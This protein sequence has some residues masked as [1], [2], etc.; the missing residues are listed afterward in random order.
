MLV[1][2]C[3]AALLAGC[4]SGRSSEV[5]PEVLDMADRAWIRGD[6]LRALSLLDET[7]AESPDAFAAVYR[8]AVL[9]LESDP[10]RALEGFARAAALDPGHPGPP[11]FTGIL[12]LTRNEFAAADASMQRAHDLQLRRRGFTLEDTTEVVRQALLDLD[13]ERW[14]DA[15]QGFTA[16]I[17]QDP[18]EGALYYLKAEAQLGGGFLT[19]ALNTVR[20]AAEKSPRLAPARALHG[21]F[22]FGRRKIEP[23]RAEADAAL[24]A[25]PDFPAALELHGRIVLFETE[26]QDGA[27]RIWRAL[28]GNPTR[29]IVLEIFA[30]SLLRTSQPQQA[31]AFFRYMEAVT[32]FHDR[33]LGKPAPATYRKPAAEADSAR[34][35]GG[36]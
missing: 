9:R 29:P 13:A 11:L 32:A 14:A 3:I 28:L 6:S 25:I 5:P 2:G 35:P 21:F 26:Y 24:A 4:G 36:R 15:A 12:Q 19:D 18:A 1:L 10:A 7:V 27:L 22:L 23:A 17:E 34:A 8:L 16:A 33:R 31:T 20:T 30:N